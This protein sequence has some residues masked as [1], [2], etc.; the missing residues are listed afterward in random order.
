MSVYDHFFF[1]LSGVTISSGLI[2]RTVASLSFLLSCNSQ[3]E[4]SEDLRF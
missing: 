1:F 4:S 2:W 3:K